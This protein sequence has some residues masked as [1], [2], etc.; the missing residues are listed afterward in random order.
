ML[1]QEQIPALF[2]VLREIAVVRFD[3][4]GKTVLCALGW[5]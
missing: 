3:S 5:R 1:G 2:A 4:E